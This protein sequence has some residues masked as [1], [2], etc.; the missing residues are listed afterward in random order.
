M[1]RIALRLAR[2]NSA[3]LW[4]RAR[5]RQVI[6]AELVR[7]GVG[8]VTGKARR[9]QPH[10][11]PGS[12]LLA[13]ANASLSRQDWREANRCLREHF[14]TRP[15][16]FLIHP[17]A[18]ATLTQAI[19]TRYPSSTADAKA[20]AE[21]I[22]RGKY[23]LLGYRDLS[24]RSS[25]ADPDWHF[26]P[27]HRR[28]APLRFWAHLPYLDPSLGDHKVIW[29]INRHQHW[30]ALGRAAWLTGERRFATAALKELESWLDANPPLAGINWASMLELAFRSISWIWALHLFVP[31]D[32][33]WDRPW[34]VD[35][36]GG[37]ERQLDHVASH[38]S[39]YFSP[40]THLL[41]EGLAL[42][43]A[44]RVLP[45]LRSAARWER[46]GRSILLREAAAQV[47]PDGG[48]AELST[49]YHRYA[50]DFY[51]LALAI[52]RKTAD[53]CAETFADAAGR[54][55]AFCRGVALDDGRLPAIGDDDGGLLFPICGRKPS[56]ASDSL[57]LAA[58]LLDRPELA[59]GDPPE[60]VLWM[61]GP[62]DARPSRRF[63]PAPE[64][65]IFPE[66]GYVVLRSADGHAVF[67]GGPHGFLN[68]GHAHADALSLVLSIRGR[69]LLI[70][71]GTATYLA[72][73][74][75]RDRFRSTAMH[76]AVV[77]DGAA[78]SVPDGAFQ[79][80]SRANARFDFWRA[81]PLGY[82]EAS[83]DGYLPVLH[84]RAVVQTRS[85][86]WLVVDHILGTGRH[87]IDA[88]WHLDP[89]WSLGQ[90]SDRGAALV[91]VDGSSAEI[92]STATS[93]LHSRGEAGGLGFCSPVYG[94][95]VPSLTLTSTV[96]E[97]TP[98][99]VVTAIAGSPAPV[100]LA[101]EVAP[102]TAERE[103]GWHRA[104]VSI[105][106]NDVSLLALFATPL[107]RRPPVRRSV[108]RTSAGVG[109]LI[110]DAR[111][112]VL[113]FATPDCRGEP[114]AYDQLDGSMAAWT[115]DGAFTLPATGT[116]ADLHCDRTALR[117]FS[118]GANA[119]VG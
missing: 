104:A 64:S 46:L 58:C 63:R 37:L 90:M 87:R 71:P 1:R 52:A 117:Q 80:K 105:R 75:L 22:L 74:D 94:E 36:L 49:H 25:V 33:D 72:D 19:R 83:H 6:A 13:D 8:R 50:L 82:A 86:V 102:V 101:V 100:R 34:L 114:T 65:R 108:Q 9:L 2:M 45:E 41:G 35:L 96:F 15:P 111:V 44:G 30:L 7:F 109:D 91:H 67:D 31:F 93:W 48:H 43:V 26:D 47:H 14:V 116:A 29:E 118:R 99:T 4:Y 81:A 20:R 69:P 56:D 55:A 77:V 97:G 107:A 28:R 92:V 110:T 66:T 16:R 23:E 21:S 12:A 51:C 119:R 62:L 113:T 17:S 98:L 85:G 70:D 11:V 68:G 79:W 59:I 24:F 57:A 103:D 32:D 89:A 3:E 27:V 84:R 61:M 40:N 53:D 115:G 76:N 38:L 78:Q 73:S 18:R 54:L 10:L 106:G 42:Y 5:E 112:A 39:F 95:V 60:E 88:Y